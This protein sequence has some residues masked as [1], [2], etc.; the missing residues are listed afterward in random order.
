MVIELGYFTIGVADVNRAV[1]FYGALFGWTFEEPVGASYAHV[2]NT[3]L[4]LGLN[5]ACLPTF[6]ASIF[7]W[8]ISRRW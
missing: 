7:A 5:K 8:T 4:P 1:K 3:K 6:Q 2:N